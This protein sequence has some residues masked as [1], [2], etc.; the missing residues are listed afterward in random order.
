M[1]TVRPKLS[2]IISLIIWGLWF[3][4]FGAWRLV[5]QKLPFRSGQST[6]KIITPDEQPIF[7]WC[8]VVFCLGVGVFGL[9][10]AVVELASWKQ[11]RRTWLTSEHQQIE[12]FSVRMIP[13]EGFPEFEYA[14]AHAATALAIMQRLIP[15]VTPHKEYSELIKILRKPSRWPEAHRHFTKI[16]TNITLPSDAREEKGLDAHFINV[17][18][19]A[20]KTAYNCSGKPAPFD[21]DSFE[22]LLCAEKLFLAALE[23]GVAK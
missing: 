10:R 4:G 3:F 2:G 22:R 11:S 6:H 16:R 17:A 20:A 7:F 23:R 19:N 21:H 12:H 13:V 1:T 9:Y 15:H 5:R 18:E 14:P 8:A